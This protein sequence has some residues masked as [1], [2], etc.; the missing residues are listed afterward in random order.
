[1]AR[2]AKFVVW[3]SG[4]DRYR[5]RRVCHTF[6][7]EAQQRDGDS[8]GAFAYSV[9]FARLRGAPLAEVTRAQVLRDR[10][11]A[12]YYLFEASE[13]PRYD[14]AALEQ[15]PLYRALDQYVYGGRKRAKPFICPIEGCNVGFDTM[16][17]LQRHLK[18]H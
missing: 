7:P 13:V 9:L 1:M 8:C 2:V 11:F 3:L 15:D 10:R 5:M 14:M 17:T 16:M 18:D 12:L 4:R 6:G